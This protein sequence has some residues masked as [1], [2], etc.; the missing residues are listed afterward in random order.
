MTKKRHPHDRRLT[1]PVSLWVSPE[2]TTRTMQLTRTI[3]TKQTENEKNK[4]NEQKKTRKQKMKKRHPHLPQ[5]HRHGR[6]PDLLH[7]VHEGNCS[8]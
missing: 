1:L 6:T 8:Y 3:T 5:L 4:K 7:A 2:R